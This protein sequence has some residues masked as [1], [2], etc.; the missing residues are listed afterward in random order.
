MKRTGVIISICF[1]HLL[2]R[3]LT[4]FTLIKGR[5]VLQLHSPGDA[6]KNMKLVKKAEVLTKLI[7]SELSTYLE[8]MFELKDIGFGCNYRP[9][10]SEFEN[11]AFQ[12]GFKNGPSDLPAFIS[13]NDAI[14]QEVEQ[15]FTHRNFDSLSF[16]NCFKQTH[17]T[18]L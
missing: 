18:H 15:W 11:Y 12:I 14:T 2:D 17:H 4:D 1:D 13:L 5:P 8:G 3:Y 16:L 9:N 7:H 10:G 6:Q